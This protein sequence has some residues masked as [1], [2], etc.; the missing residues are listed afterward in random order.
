MTNAHVVAAANELPQTAS[1]TTVAF[2]DGRTAPF[3]V[4]AA[5]PESDI[6]V[7]RADAMSGLTA[8]ALG[9]SADLRIG[10]PVAA[11]GSPLD[12]SGTITVGVVSAL[13]RPVFG[14]ADGTN[15]AA[16]YRP[17]KPTLRSIRETRAAPWLT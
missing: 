13:D 8:I 12:L 11:I 9:S 15:Q 3:T 16:A 1:G 10:E 14:V 6:A 2:N 7:V 17:S 5:D 4:V